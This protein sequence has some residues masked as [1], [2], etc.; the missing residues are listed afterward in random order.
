MTCSLS[1]SR[2]SVCYDFTTVVLLIVNR[3]WRILYD[4]TKSQRFSVVP[5]VRAAGGEGV[6]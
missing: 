2:V 6:W 1:P 4:R 3:L 5:T